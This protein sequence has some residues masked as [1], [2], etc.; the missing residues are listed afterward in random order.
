MNTDTTAHLVGQPT[1]SWLGID[2]DMASG[3]HGYGAT[4][5]DLYDVS[6]FLGRSAQTVLLG[7][8]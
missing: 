6:G 4:F 8:R 3:R 7:P 2:A 1:T 5:A